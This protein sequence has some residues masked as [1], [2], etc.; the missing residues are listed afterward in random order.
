MVRYDT[1]TNNGSRIKIIQRGADTMPDPCVGMIR[2]LAEGRIGIG[3]CVL[4]NGRIGE[5]MHLRPA[6][7]EGKDIQ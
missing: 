2:R 1:R 4:Q 7:D 6:G 3:G 5:D